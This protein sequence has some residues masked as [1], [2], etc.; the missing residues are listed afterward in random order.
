MKKIALLLVCL[1]V[2]SYAVTLSSSADATLE[3]GYDNTVFILSKN[4]A[5]PDENG[6]IFGV[7][8]SAYGNLEFIDGKN[9]SDSRVFTAILVSGDAVGCLETVLKDDDVITAWVNGGEY[10]KPAVIVTVKGSDLPVLGAADEDG[11]YTYMGVKVLAFRF[12]YRTRKGNANA[13]TTNMVLLYLPSQSD[14][15]KALDTLESN[16]LVIS[17]GLD[18]ISY[19]EIDDEYYVHGDINVDGKADAK[20][21]A[22]LK[23]HCLGTYEIDKSV[24]FYADI[25]GNGYID[26]RDYVLLKRIILK[27]WQPPVLDDSYEIP[28]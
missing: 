18:S 7:K 19:A 2:F 26:T 10:E 28:W 9:P 14:V 16:P 21:Y 20:D 24:S 3:P 13:S 12:D 15:Q 22:L 17:V 8:C 11:L 5:V 27:T 4:V 6:V 1:L 25:D 23:R